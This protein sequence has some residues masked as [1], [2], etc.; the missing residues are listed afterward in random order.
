[1]KRIIS[2]ILTLVVILGMSVMFT[3]CGTSDVENKEIPETVL[4]E[5]PLFVDIGN[6]VTVDGVT[7]NASTLALNFEDDFYTN[8]Q[9]ASFYVNRATK[10]ILL[11]YANHGSTRGG[12]YVLPTGMRYEGTI[13]VE[14]IAVPDIIN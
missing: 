14:G 10:E 9:S 7:W 1:M 5:N 12:A 11:V 8:G 2:V 6:T 4:D 13:T 3:A